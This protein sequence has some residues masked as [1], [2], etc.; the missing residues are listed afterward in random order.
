MNFEVTFFR[1]YALQILC[2]PAM[3]INLKLNPAAQSENK[4]GLVKLG[5]MIKAKLNI[6]NLPQTQTRI[7]EFQ[8]ET[9]T[10]KICSYNLLSINYLGCMEKELLVKTD[11]VMLHRK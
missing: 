6:S 1:L 9:F 5:L 11:N 2:D 7:N 8:M 4:S 10:I 3:M